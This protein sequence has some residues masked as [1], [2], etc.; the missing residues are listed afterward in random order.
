MKPQFFNVTLEKCDYE[1]V[2]P[3][4]MVRLIAS[5]EVFFFRQENFPDCQ[6]VL[7]KL[8]S[9][10]QLKIGAHRLKDGTYWLHWLHH[11]A[12]GYLESNKNYVF[13]F[14]MLC[15]FVIGM[16]VV[17]SGVWVH[18]L[19]ISSKNNDFSDVIF[20]AFVTILMLAGFLFHC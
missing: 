8:E 3:E 4:N 1:N 6:Q 20:M 11:A 12:K 13:K 9:G 19:N 17:F 15:S 2:I 14:S 16:M 5:G 18:Y 10:D 7:R